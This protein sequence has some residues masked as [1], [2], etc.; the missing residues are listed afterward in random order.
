MALF[1]LQK[2]IRKVVKCVR[3]LI[4]YDQI[5]ISAQPRLYIGNVEHPQHIGLN[6]ISIEDKLGSMKGICI[7]TPSETSSVFPITSYYL[8]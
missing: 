1:H 4:I 5:R 2:F 7:S 8:F 6:Y 3:S